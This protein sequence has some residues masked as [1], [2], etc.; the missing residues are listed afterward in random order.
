VMTKVMTQQR[1]KFPLGSD[2]DVCTHV[3]IS[4]LL[5]SGFHSE[6]V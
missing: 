1:G 4:A 2:K 5:D 3:A 6:G